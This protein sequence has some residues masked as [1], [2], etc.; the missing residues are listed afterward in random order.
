MAA[1]IKRLI[2]QLL[3]FVVGIVLERII[4]V[5]QSPLAPKS[6]H[7]HH[8]AW[9]WSCLLLFLTWWNFG[10]YYFCYVLIVWMLLAIILIIR[11]YHHYQEL[12]YRRYWPAFWR[13]TFVISA[14]AYLCSWALQNLPEP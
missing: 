4:I 2:I 8:L 14:I 13:M 1:N 11:Q 5:L 12:I 7:R 10:G 6:G 9:F 3:I